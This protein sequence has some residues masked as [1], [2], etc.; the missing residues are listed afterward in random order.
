[1]TKK[2]ALAKLG[3]TVYYW[4]SDLPTAITW[5]TPIPS[6]TLTEIGEKNGLV[7]GELNTRIWGV[8]DANTINIDELYNTT[9]EAKAALKTTYTVRAALNAE[10]AEAV[11][12]I[13]I[14]PNPEPEPEP[15]EL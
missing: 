11:D 4:T 15:I 5:Q 10:L 7:D 13:G 1:M 3:K 9:A 14:D 6:G 2:Q 12:S 8:T